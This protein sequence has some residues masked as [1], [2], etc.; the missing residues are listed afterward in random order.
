VRIL[1]VLKHAGYFGVYP[2]LVAELAR[3]GHH[4]HIGWL[5]GTAEDFAAL[6]RA[7]AA[8]PGVTHGRA[9]RRGTLDGWSSVAFLTRALGDLGRYSD[10]RFAQSTALRDRMAGKVESHLEGAAGFDPLTRRLALRQARGLHSRSDA[11]LAQR[12][13]ARSARLE[14]GVPPGARITEY[15]RE[16]RPDVVLVS[17]LIELASPLLDYLKA[18]RALGIRTGICVASWDNLTSKGLLR[19]VPER[20]FVWNETQR[21]EANELH[22]IPAER[23]VA[24]GAARFDDWFAQRPSS[25]REEFMQRVGLD[26][27]AASVAG[28][29]GDA[30]PEEPGQPYLLYLCSSVF[31]APDEVSFV[32]RWLA[33]LRER[34][35][36]V[37]V[38]VRPHPK[39]AEPWADVDLGPNAVVWPRRTGGP[40]AETRAG[41]YDSIAHSAGVVGANTSAMIEAA[42]AGKPV[43]TLLAPEFNQSETIHFHYLRSEQGGFLHVAATIEE[44]LDQLA[45]GIAHEAEE[46]DRARSFVASFVRPGGIDRSATE[47]YANAVEELAALPAPE[48]EGPALGPRAALAPL[49]AI[50]SLALA[51]RVGKAALRSKLRTT[52][53][54]KPRAE[55]VQGQ[56]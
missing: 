50:S 49:A 55:Q 28:E 19:F 53:Q 5:S 4:V 3:R 38:I 48:P 26:A 27:A 2:Q 16:Q 24:T 7:A 33:A 56:A 8:H 30:R 25:S 20:V 23:V 18:A 46:S 35:G 34:L 39:R 22:G 14:A 51:T 32:H 21:C 29:A 42:I 17:P 41:F 54:P 15:I 44:H 13:I 45:A 43:Y 37:G 11:S 1:L 40:D 31:V 10:P 52:E 47:I 9:P 12:S 36:D 6:D